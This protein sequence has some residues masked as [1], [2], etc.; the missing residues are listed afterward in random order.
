M[1]VI[2]IAGPYRADTV[3]G[4][5]E[6]IRRAEQWAIYFWRKGYAV[7]CPHKNTALFDG[8]ADDKIWLKGD[9][10]IMRRCDSVFAMP[11]WNR[12]RGARAEIKEAKR[13]GL[14]IIYGPD[15]SRA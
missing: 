10:E 15:E 8:I 14:E 9:L 5:K 1:E 7:I 6:N 12:S 3:Q 13:I 2:Y 11:G 4:V